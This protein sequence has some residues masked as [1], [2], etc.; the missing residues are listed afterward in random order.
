MDP[1]FSASQ[2]SRCSSRVGATLPLQEEPLGWPTG[3]RTRA[4]TPTW[5]SRSRMASSLAA[6]LEVCT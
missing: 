3:F 4:T 2:R 1:V 6:A 5:R